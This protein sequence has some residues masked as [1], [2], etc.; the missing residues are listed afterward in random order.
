MER[1]VVRKDI[2]F[3]SENTDCAGWLYVS[4]DKKQPVIIMAHGLGATRDMRLENM[5]LSLPK[6]ALPVFCL[7]TETTGTAKAT[8][9]TG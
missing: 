1:K 5:P 6:P 2:W 3:L 8:S 9:A 7:I 4:D